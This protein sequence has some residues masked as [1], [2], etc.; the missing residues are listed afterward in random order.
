MQFNNSN[1]NVLQVMVV[2]FIVCSG[3]QLYSITFC[4]FIVI[5]IACIAPHLTGQVYLMKGPV[6]KK[7][8]IL[9]FSRNCERASSRM[10]FQKK[11]S[12]QRFGHFVNVMS[13]ISLT[14]TSFPFYLRLHVLTCSFLCGRVSPKVAADKH[15]PKKCP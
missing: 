10:F 11:Y 9:M 1:K 3:R 13:L 14:S 2:A 7:H 5:F 12:C 4:V 15:T 6:L 8:F